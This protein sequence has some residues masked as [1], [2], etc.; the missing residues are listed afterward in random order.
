MAEFKELPPAKL[1]CNIFKLIDEDWMLVT[2][3]SIESWNTMTASWGGLGTLWNMPVAFCFVRPTRHT[4]GFMERAERF[5]LSFFP[6][7]FR[8]ALNYCGSKSGRDVDKAKETGL[9]PVAGTRGTVH[10]EQARLVLE[11]RKLYFQDLKPENFL[12]PG[13]EKLYPEK[14]FHRMYIGEVDRCLVKP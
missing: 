9:R 10:F 5:T 1:S 3:G 13:I 6:E 12:D 11:C 14:D 7:E 8:Q 2:A 4:Y